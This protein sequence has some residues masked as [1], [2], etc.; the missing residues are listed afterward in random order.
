MKEVEQIEIEIT[1][2]KYMV[3]L[4]DALARLEKNKDFKKVFEEEYFKN[5]AGRLI[6]ARANFNLSP[7]QRNNILNMLDSIGFLQ[8]FFR[9]IKVTAEQMKQTIAE[10]EETREEMLR[11][12][13]ANG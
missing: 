12:E 3:D 1:Q 4:G 8:Q 6:R 11:E 2:A 13:I 10:N 7:E 5:E 9:D